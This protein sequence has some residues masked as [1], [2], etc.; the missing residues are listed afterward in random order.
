MTGTMTERAG[1]LDRAALRT[2][3]AATATEVAGRLTDPGETAAAACSW[4]ASGLDEGHPGVALLFAELSHHDPRHRP[5][6]HAHL[7][8][9]VAGL[10]YALQG[11]LYAG[12]P[13]L[14]FAAHTAR[15]APEDYAGLL[16]QLDPVVVRAVRARLD[17]DRRR[18][19]ARRAG[20]GFPAYDLISGLTGLTG[21]LLARRPADDPTLTEAVT[22]LLRLLEPLPREGVPVPGWW[23][24]GGHRGDDDAEF[25][26]G[27]LNFG[28]A[29]GITGVLSV[30]VTAHQAQVPAPGIGEAVADLAALLLERRTADGRWP[31]VVPLADFTAG[32]TAHAGRSAWCYGTPG[33]AAVLHRA[34]VALDR[35]DWRRTAVDAALR[36]LGEPLGVGDP[37]ICHG[38]A[39]LLHLATVLRHAS[40]DARFAALQDRFAAR[41][42]DAH[43]PDRPFGFGWAATDTDEVVNCA[44]L[45]TGASGIA[46]ALHAY[47][48]G[49]PPAGGWDAALLLS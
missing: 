45:L 41:A 22:H 13:A 8:A 49:A 38:W 21:L 48:T 46:L 39:G 27:H 3:A 9:A 16:H 43:D 36:D 4:S 17:E 10:P 25:P 33:V 1:G 30:L 2:R 44:G 28:V 14:V 42:L 23:T 37:G 26:D 29:H 35:P 5:A 34:G 11:G 24:P 7:K 40:G 15:Q 18:L 32:R 19:T 47:A 6:V 20:L 12:V 31:A